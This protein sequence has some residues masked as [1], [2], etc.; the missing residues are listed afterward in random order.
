MM[1]ISKKG[2]VHPKSNQ[3]PRCADQ[4]EIPRFATQKPRE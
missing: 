4:F 1:T 3:L 2:S